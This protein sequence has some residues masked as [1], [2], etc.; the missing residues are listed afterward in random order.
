MLIPKRPTKAKS[1]PVPGTPHRITKAALWHAR[2]SI[3]TARDDSRV[4]KGAKTSRPA[5]CIAP[6]KPITVAAKVGW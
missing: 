4:R 2:I 3:V 1:P 5:T 6:T